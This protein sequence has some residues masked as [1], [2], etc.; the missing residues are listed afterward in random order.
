MLVLSVVLMG[1]GLEAGSLIFPSCQ[2]SSLRVEE[3]VRDITEILHKVH[4]G[5]PNT[6][7]VL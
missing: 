6:I 7:K 4:E 1:L 2:K 5:L 3:F